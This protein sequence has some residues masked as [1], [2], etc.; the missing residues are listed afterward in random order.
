[1]KLPVLAR[2]PLPAALSLAG[3]T[4]EC[5]TKHSRSINTDETDS[6]GR[7]LRFL[8][9]TT[10]HACSSHVVPQSIPSGS[11]EPERVEGRRAV[12]SI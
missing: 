10:H 9:E 11:Y 6:K 12:G 8:F 3:N 1:M 5:G 2:C 4:P 7:L